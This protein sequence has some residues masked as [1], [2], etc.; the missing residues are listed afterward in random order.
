VALR[1]CVVVLHLHP[2]CLILPQ[3]PLDYRHDL[4]LVVP[5]FELG[6]SLCG[7]WLILHL[8]RFL[9]AHVSNGLVEV[10]VSYLECPISPQRS[11][12]FTLLYSFKV[13]PSF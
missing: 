4:E 7:G 6:L 2:P 12:S 10:H 11:K 8:L 13:A 5:H 1:F 3:P 9:W